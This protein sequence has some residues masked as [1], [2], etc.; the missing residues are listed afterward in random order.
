MHYS[1]LVASSLALGA[2]AR[3][4]I[5]ERA[6]RY[7]VITETAIETVTILVTVTVDINLPTG[8]S[9]SISVDATPTLSST[10]TSSSQSGIAAPGAGSDSITTTITIGT[11][12]VY[13]SSAAMSLIGLPTMGT[14]TSSVSSIASSVVLPGSSSI[15]SSVSSA[16]PSPTSSSPSITVGPSHISGPSQA[17]LSSGP[18]YTAA[19]LYHHNAA[20]ANHG[21][22]EMTWCPD[23]ETAARTTAE[24]C[25]FEHSIPAGVNQGQNLFTVSGDAFNVTAGITE[26]WYKAEL[27]FM[28]GYYGMANIP[29]DV[30]HKVGHFTQVVWI[31]STSV[32]CVSQDCTGRMIV[33]GASS[34]LDKFTVC[35]Y[36]PAGNVNDGYG[37][38]VLPPI[39]NNLGRWDD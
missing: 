17:S 16:S 21:A 3:P 32:G 38:N 23:C 8:D 5:E 15:A 26:S 1:I 25:I 37:L 22:G 14:P 30:F 27:P 35:N 4:H 24:L 6:R 33:N 36:D 13:S 31:D 9:A 2:F 12:S 19:V 11:P 18:D 10:S 39:S 28:D 7:R 20:R 34:N 29:D